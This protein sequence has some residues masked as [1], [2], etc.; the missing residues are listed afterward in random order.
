MLIKSNQ[1]CCDSRHIFS[2]LSCS[3]SSNIPCFKQLDIDIKAMFKLQA[4]VIQIK[5]LSFLFMPTLI[6]FMVVS[7]AQ[8]TWNPHQSGVTLI[9]GPRWFLP[10]WLLTSTLR[11][12][13]IHLWHQRYIT[14]VTILHCWELGQQ[15]TRTPTICQRNLNEQILL[16]LWICSERCLCFSFSFICSVE[17]NLC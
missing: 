6:F 5:F 13:F 8:T 10:R 15:K 1:L 16:H 11:S 14:D 17:Y 2:L 4:K 9:C 7:T 3:P 12:R